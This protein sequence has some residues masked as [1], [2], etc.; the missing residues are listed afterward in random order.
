MAK[1]RPLPGKRSWS[2]P[3]AII[4]NASKLPW[5]SV[6]STHSLAYWKHHNCECKRVFNAIPFFTLQILWPATGIRSPCEFPSSYSTSPYNLNP[7]SHRSYNT[8][9]HATISNRDF[10]HQVTLDKSSGRTLAGGMNVIKWA[11]R[12][13]LGDS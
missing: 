11:K 10:H 8:T 2:L 3:V 6:S 1:H 4:S 5:T 7:A 13:V 12:N 9:H